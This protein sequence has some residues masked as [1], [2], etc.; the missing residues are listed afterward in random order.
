VRRDG[1]WQLLGIADAL[2]PQEPTAAK[3]DPSVLAAYAGEYQWAP[4]LISK[5]EPR[6]DRLLEHLGGG[7]DAAEWLPETDTTFFVPGEAAGG[8]SSRI[9]FVKDAGGRVTHYIYRARGE[10]D[11]IVKKVK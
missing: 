3:I 2:I 4:T 6:S 5:I 11:R 10:T 1:R 8:D 7:G 9:I